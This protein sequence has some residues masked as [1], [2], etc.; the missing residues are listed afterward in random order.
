[1]EDGATRNR[2]PIQATSEWQFQALSAIIGAGAP[3]VAVHIQ[4]PN[5]DGAAGLVYLD[6]L[7]LAE[8]NLQASEPPQFDTAQAA[9][10]LWNGRQFTNLL[11]NGSGESS[12]PSLRPW[13]SGLSLYGKPASR[14][15]QSLWD[16]PRTAWVYSTEVSNLLQSFW[17][18][19]GWNHVSLP[20]SF[21]YVLGFLTLAAILGVAK[22][23]FRVLGSP[24]KI[25]PWQ[26]SAIFLVG[27]MAL[28][29]WAATVLRIHP[30]FV[31][32]Q[33]V[34]WPV[35]RYAS[36]V[37]VPTALL[38][39]LGWAQIVP[40]RWTKEAAYFGLLG[41]VALDAASM[42]TAILPYYYG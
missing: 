41:M 21:F 6:G 2:H 27:L 3:S 9:A 35:A 36:V 22:S 19:F 26:R 40:R 12:W 10:G 33:R 29:A 15:F 32:G 11:R 30:V 7:V 1:V 14:I 16:W 38:L 42:W 4:I 13:T 24:E 8:G 34:F 18:R 17:G 5:S 28:V 25:A 31:V 20:T 37:M 39:C 23:L